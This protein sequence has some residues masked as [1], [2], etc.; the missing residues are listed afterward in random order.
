MKESVSYWQRI[1]M[2]EVEEEK[3]LSPKQKKIAKLDP[4]EDKIDA[5]DF[6][7]L[8]AGKK[9]KEASINEKVDMEELA[10]EL[11]RLKSQN[12]GK[13]ITYSFIT[14]SKYPKGYV[15]R[16]DGKIQEAGDQTP[17]PPTDYGGKPSIPGLGPIVH[18]D[19]PDHEVSMASNSL[20]TIIKAAM[21]LKAK[22][23]NEEKDIPAWIQDHIT[24]AENFITQ[25]S[26]NYHEYSD[27]AMYE[28]EDDDTETNRP[29]NDYF[30]RRSKE[31]SSYF[32]INRDTDNEDDDEY[33]SDYSRRR[34]KEDGKPSFQD[35]MEY[36]IK[37]RNKNSK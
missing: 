33:V 29:A 36:L 2:Q 32:G 10:M 30:K 6:K 26:Q 5:G 24:N 34:A 4:P 35:L 21:E 28:E 12:P 23:G 1:L 14:N 19:Q 22:L 17:N 15:I 27:D 13:K 18:E 7:A 11:A 37:K 9:I 20:E 31:D 16:I 8:R 25:A 3:E